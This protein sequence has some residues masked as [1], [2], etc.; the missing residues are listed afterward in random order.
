MPF[1]PCKLP[2]G[3]QETFSQLNSSICGGNISN[4]AVSL[5]LMTVCGKHVAGFEP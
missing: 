2:G 5:E 1:L 3:S 4:T